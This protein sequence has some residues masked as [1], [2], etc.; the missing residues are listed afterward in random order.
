MTDNVQ[1]DKPTK[2]LD[3]I[4]KLIAAAGSNPAKLE[5]PTDRWGFTSK[6]K[7]EILKAASTVK[8]NDEKHDLLL[9]TLAVLAAH[10]KARKESDKQ[11]QTERLERIREFHADLGPRERVTG[12]PANV[13][14]VAIPED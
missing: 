2:P 4:G 5:F 6:I 8:G 9:G 10:I 1:G 11:V 3:G 13:E 7:T 12:R 14:P